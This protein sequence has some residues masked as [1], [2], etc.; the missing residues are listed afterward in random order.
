MID[1]YQRWNRHLVRFLIDTGVLDEKTGNVWMEHSDYIPF[2][3]AMEGE[4]GFKG[5]QIF[6]GMQLSPFKRAKGS[7]EKNIVDPITGITNN[8]RAAINAG[9]KNVAANRT[10]RNLVIIKAAEQVKNNTA[11]PNIVKI[12]VKGKTK[13]FSV[14][15]P[16]NYNLFTV[17]T[18]GD[19]LPTN[20]LMSVMRGSK[21]MVS[22]LITRMPDFWFRQVV[23]DSMSAWFLSGANY[24]PILSQLKESVNITYGM[25]TGNLP[26][27]YV[28]LRNAGIIQGYERGVRD[29]DSTQALVENAYKKERY[30]EKTTLSK[31]ATAPL[32]IITKVWDILGQGTAITD[33]ATRVSV[34]KDTLKR[35][36]DVAEALSQAMEVLNF[37]RRGNNKAFQL[38]T[39]S[40]MFLNPRLQGVDVF[41]RGL[42]GKY[43]IGRGLT[44]RKRAAAVALRMLSYISLMP[45]YYLLVRDS[46]EWEEASE[47]TKDNY[48]IFQYLSRLVG[49]TVAL[50]KPF[51]VGLLAMTIPERL[52]AYMLDDDPAKDFGDSLVRNISHTFA[53]SPPTAI[54]PLVENFF[55]YDLYT[56][57]P[58]VPP[59]MKGQDDLAFR[60]STSSLARKLG[61]A[62]DTSPLYWDNII[63]DYTG[64]MGTYAML[65]VD[66][67]LRDSSRGN[68]PSLRVDQLPV[69]GT[70]LLNPEGSGL[71]NEFFELKKMTDDLV[72]S[73]R[74]LENHYDTG[75]RSVMKMT[76]EYKIQYQDAVKKLQS[77]LLPLADKMKQARE[78]ETY[79]INH[80]TLSADDKR[81]KLNS[82]RRTKNII[83]ESEK[84]SEQRFKFIDD[85]RKRAIS[86]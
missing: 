1:D 55:N 42:T 41:Y 23:R 2:Y 81:D 54:A 53:V 8:A 22:D 66:S 9:M 58:I 45:Y 17:M 50:P 40:T 16:D 73:F 65:A 57:R 28:A 33:A 15:D 38:V 74:V 11:G 75:D 79:I 34:Y 76:D 85:Y 12:K 84:I 69:I 43:G 86:R 19:F 39:Q 48:I 7:E 5:P 49:S 37:T 35:T 24:V 26:E 67:V 64:S 63:R 4:E 31:V 30:K 13:S 46:E 71:E 44:R 36:G 72:E 6:Q 56:G 51:E 60:P 82:I 77:D 29:I 68:R 47:E 62:T 52:M 18:G 59:Y 20:M 27:E 3:R 80:P 25:M 10:M 14:D 70:F 21:R 61:D 78:Y 32:D 83:L